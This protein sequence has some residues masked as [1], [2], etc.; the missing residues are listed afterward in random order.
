MALPQLACHAGGRGFESR[1]SRPASARFLRSGSSRPPSTHPARS[2]LSATTPRTTA[3]AS[4]PIP[5]QPAPRHLHLRVVVA[6]DVAQALPLVLERAAVVL[7]TAV[8]AL[9]LASR[10]PRWGRTRTN[11]MRAADM[12]SR[13]RGPVAVAVRN[14][15]PRR[16]PACRRKCVVHRSRKCRRIDRGPVDLQRD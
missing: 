14:E 16:V 12:P 1:R 4:T 6:F 9:S 11:R 13:V 7:P 15:E 3:G 10:R 2:R 5:T 8:L